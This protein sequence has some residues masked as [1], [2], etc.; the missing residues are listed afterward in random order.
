MNSFALNMINGLVT[1]LLTFA[2]TR[3]FIDKV[4][5]YLYNRNAEKKR[6]KGQS[7]IEWFTYSRFKDRLPKKFYVWYYANFVYFFLFVVCM[8]VLKAI[9][10][11]Q[12][13]FVL[14]IYLFTANIPGSY[15][16]FMI[17][18]LYRDSP[19]MENVVNKKHGNKRK[20]K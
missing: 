15:Y 18:G 11:S 8:I 2:A 3:G 1:L 17:K 9:G 6:K 5:S 19:H 20:K 12:F 7:F 4:V 13:K 16:W 10:I 14:L